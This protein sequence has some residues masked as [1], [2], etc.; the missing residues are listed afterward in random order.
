MFFR[1]FDSLSKENVLEN[2]KLAFSV[3]ENE[4][5]IAALLDA[6]DMLAM[7]IPDKLSIITYVSQ[8]YNCLSKLDTSGKEK[9]TVLHLFYLAR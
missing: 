7:K 2:N 1:N 3:A 8:Y 4:L 5:D 6:E 9:R